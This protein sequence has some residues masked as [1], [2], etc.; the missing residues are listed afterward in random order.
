MDPENDLDV[1]PP[2]LIDDC[3]QLLTDAGVV[4]RSQPIELRQRRGDTFTCGSEQAVIYRRGP[5]AIRYSPSPLVSCGLA[6]ALARFEGLLQ[7]AAEE[8]LGR[9]VARVEHVGTYNCRKMAQYPDWVSEHSY[10]NAID[11]KAFVLSDGRRI[12]VLRHFGKLDREATS[13][14]STFLR[15]FARSLF[16]EDVFSV[17]LTPYFDALHKDHFHLDLARY[18]MDGTH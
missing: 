1:G 15:H 8:K 9:R 16:T 13:P 7:N 4:F 11:I 5:G 12:S 18:R 6:L 10:A 3:E 17:V 14:E 2:D